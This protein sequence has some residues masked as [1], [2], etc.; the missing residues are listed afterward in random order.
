M[1]SYMK[2]SLLHCNKAEKLTDFSVSD[3]TV[4]NNIVY[5]VSEEEYIYSIFE[6]I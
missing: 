3:F 4:L 6:L 5:Y 2:I 1:E